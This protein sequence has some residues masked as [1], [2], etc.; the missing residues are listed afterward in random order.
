M[1]CGV[2]FIHVVIKLYALR[3]LNNPA[4]ALYENE[5]CVLLETYQLAR[6]KAKIYAFFVL[7]LISYARLSRRQ[8]F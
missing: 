7:M 8:L 6:Y 1:F 4:L 5:T 3:K 2:L